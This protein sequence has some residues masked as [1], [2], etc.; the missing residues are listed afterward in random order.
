MGLR[1]YTLVIKHHGQSKSWR[2]MFVSDYSFT[3]QSL[4]EKTQGTNLKPETKAEAIEELHLLTSSNTFPSGFLFNYLI[5]LH[6]RCPPAP[7]PRVLHTNSISPLSLRGYFLSSCHTTSI[8]LPLSLKSLL[9]L[10]HSFQQRPEK[11]V[12]S[13][14]CTVRPSL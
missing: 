4:T 12:L 6:S 11:T 14:I 2:E 5:N 8:P 10:A 3:A 1:V 7:L 13:Y 9:Y